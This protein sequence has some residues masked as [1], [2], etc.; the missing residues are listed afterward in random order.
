MKMMREPHVLIRIQKYI[1]KSKIKIIKK[2]LTIINYFYLTYKKPIYKIRNNIIYN[3]VMP[4]IQTYPNK[5]I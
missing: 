3:T 1:L 2:M 4:N 5:N